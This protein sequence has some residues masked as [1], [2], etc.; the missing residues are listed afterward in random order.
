MKLERIIAR[1]IMGLNIDEKLDAANVFVA[2]NWLKGKTA[3]AH[4]I[5]VLLLGYLPKLGKRNQDTARL[6][7]A[8]EMH[9][10]GH[11]TGGIV[12]SRTFTMKGGSV[13]CEAKIPPQLGNADE[14][15]IM[16][17][18]GEYAA[19]TEQARRDYVFGL[20]NLSAMTEFS[21]S[22]MVGE[23]RAAVAK[24]CGEDD[25]TRKAVDALTAKIAD[26]VKE[27]APE[28]TRGCAYSPGEDP[29]LSPQQ[30]L[31][32]ALEA[33]AEFTKSAKEYAARM[34]KTVQGITTLKL[35]DT[36]PAVNLAAVEAERERVTRERE[37]IV[38]R[39]E[40]LNAQKKQIDEARR[41]RNLITETLRELQPKIE[42][43]AALKAKLAANTSNSEAAAKEM[44]ALVKT[45]HDLDTQ[46]RE[47][48][49]A[50]IRRREINHRLPAL[51]RAKDKAQACRDHMEELDK[52]F[53]FER[54]TTAGQAVATAEEAARFNANEQTRIGRDLLD[55]RRTLE[56]RETA[57]A[58]IGA[59]TQC[60]TCHAAGEGWKAL[61]T[62]ELNTEIQELT[63]KIAALS[64]ELE[65]L[66]VT[67]AEAS[68]AVMKAKNAHAELMQFGRERD[69]LEREIKDY[70][71]DAE[72]ADKL[73]A[74]LTA[75]P[76]PNAELTA[77]FGTANARWSELAKA[78]DERRALEADIAKAEAAAGDVQR[79]NAELT[80]LTPD[81]PQIEA[82]I[83][84]KVSEYNAN[85]TRANEL[86]QQ[87]RLAEKR[88][89]DA[90]RAAEAETQRTEA[91]AEVA[92]SKQAAA[93]LKEIQER[94]VRAAFDPVLKSANAHFGAILQTPLAYNDGEI[95][96]W[97]NGTWVS[98]KT[99]SGAEERLAYCAISIA[100]AARSKLKIAIIDELG[101]VDDGN[102]AKLIDAVGAALESGFITQFVGIDAGR[103][104]LYRDHAAF[105]NYVLN[106]RE[107]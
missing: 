46:L 78:A 80:A 100:L 40:E 24:A 106:V 52:R 96:T 7:S 89:N 3:R 71:R 35:Q 81:D 60:P 66:R 8:R 69:S 33:A 22:A 101:T 62:A 98:H 41:R 6:M 79:L 107:L 19:Q 86:D 29:E 68:A 34:E 67:A 76:Q 20:L 36:A 103:A 82:A 10:E 57:L 11:F 94:F 97:R 14:L 91:L 43:L 38:A 5:T 4:A 1:G 23:V 53:S 77:Q 12:L 25:A 32:V 39:R 61:R 51:K 88:Q 15:A 75:L 17:N 2:P 26:C 84:A 44:F 16:L 90:Q 30:W 85:L 95:G 65:E 70:A 49:A 27:Q 55:Y 56:G 74:E 104:K 99:F 87:R 42:A 9:L 92:V 47:I 31:G 13:K 37:A 50:G 48:D 72:E 58:S 18:F 45:R 64:D 105:T 73:E 93:T 63:G 102:A 21:E 83:Q 59:A 54:L 28:L